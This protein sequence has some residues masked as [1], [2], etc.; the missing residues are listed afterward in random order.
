MPGLADLQGGVCRALVTGD[1]SQVESLLLGGAD[2]RKRLVIHQ[3][4]YTASL[5]TALLNRF[6]ATVWLVGSELVTDAAR[7]FVRERPPSRPCIAEYGES[8][9]AFLAAHPA[10]AHLAYLHSFAELEWHLG[11]LALAVHPSDGVQYLRAEWAIDELISL[12]L[13][14]QEPERFVLDH[15][16][17][18]LEV[19]GNRGELQITRLSQA[20]FALRCRGGA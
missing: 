15:G 9:P 10:V 11:R 12:Y 14:G 17:I 13:S 18:W 6:P 2:A 4:H 8:F 19:R 20:D 5:V 16:D 1:A 3:R 7:R